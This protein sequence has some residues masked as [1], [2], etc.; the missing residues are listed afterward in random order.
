MESGALPGLIVKTDP[1]DPSKSTKEYPPTFG[2]FKP[3]KTA[4]YPGSSAIG[5]PFNFTEAR[6]AARK[7]NPSNAIKEKVTD[8]EDSIVAI[9]IYDGTKVL[10]P[11]DAG[12]DPNGPPHP[13]VKVNGRSIITNGDVHNIFK[14]GCKISGSIVFNPNYSKMGHTMKAEWSYIIINDFGGGGF[15]GNVD[16][17]DFS[18]DIVPAGRPYDSGEAAEA[19]TSESADTTPGNPNADSSSCNKYDDGF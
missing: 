16:A 19:N 7:A 10:K 1:D 2:C 11:G 3:S 18:D 12:F 15:R 17:S 5:V 9:K 8:F 13:L 14:F 4:D 6:K